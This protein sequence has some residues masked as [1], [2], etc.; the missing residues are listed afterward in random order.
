M[1][2]IRKYILPLLLIGLF[3]VACASAQPV[4]AKPTPQKQ[5]PQ[6]GQT[7]PA[8]NI[9]NFAFTPPSLTVPAGTTVTWTNNDTTTHTV[10]ADNK[11]FDSGALNPG[12]TFT[13]TFTQAGTFTY[14]CTIHPMM[15]GTIVV[16]Q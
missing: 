9:A 8:V 13:F 12:K 10:T 16:T 3:F 4:A 14:K 5:I 6:T 15:T 2:T 11:S 7:G 1:K